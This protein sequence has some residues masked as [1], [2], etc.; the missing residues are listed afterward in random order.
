M[1]ASNQILDITCEPRD[2]PL[3]LDFAIRFY[4]QNIF[5]RTDGRIKMAWS[6][7]MAG[8]YAL[9]LGTMEPYKSGPNKGWARTPGNGWTDYP[10]D[11][12]PEI[13]A[14]IA[15]QWLEKHPP[16]RQCMPCTDGSCVPAFRV[17]SY[18][19]A[20]TEGISLPGP[21]DDPEWSGSDCIL[22]LTPCWSTYDK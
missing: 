4:G 9:G 11:Y 3:V 22:I 15:A 7:P 14:R 8:T 16:D 17:R 1:Y 2:M 10:F 18:S 13:V 20:L 6:E 21:C 19:T 12:D 5:T